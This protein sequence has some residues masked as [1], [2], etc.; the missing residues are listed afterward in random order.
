V[1]HDKWSLLATAC[2]KLHS[3]SCVPRRYNKDRVADDK[4][5]VV[6]NVI[7]A[8]MKMIMFL[9]FLEDNPK[10]SKKKCHDRGS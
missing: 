7:H 6:T 4:D 1:A 9:V 5:H 2:A 10:R 8:P 3:C